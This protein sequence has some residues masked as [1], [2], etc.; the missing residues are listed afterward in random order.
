[1]ATLSVILGAASSVSVW[2]NVSHPGNKSGREN[3]KYHPDG[4]KWHLCNSSK[5][6]IWVKRSTAVVIND[7]SVGEG[8]PSFPPSFLLPGLPRPP[9]KTAKKSLFLYLVNKFYATITLAS[10]S[11]WA[12][13]GSLKPEGAGESTGDRIKHAG[14]AVVS[15]CGA[16]ESAFPTDS[17]V[18]PELRWT[19]HT[20]K[21]IDR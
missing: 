8:C 17:R 15:L 13:S 12:R 10:V 18:R 4:F 3:I 2:G 1:M 5:F 19:E 9:K 20:L 21:S 6:Y 11:R 16:R 7:S 14:L